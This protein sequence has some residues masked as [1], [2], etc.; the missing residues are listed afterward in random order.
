MTVAIFVLLDANVVVRT[1]VSFGAPVKTDPVC[2]SSR[3][4]LL[5]TLTALKLC[6]L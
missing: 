1:V 4:V 5:V 3:Q 6:G 2:L